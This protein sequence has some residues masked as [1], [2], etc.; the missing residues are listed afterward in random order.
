MLVTIL[1]F[2]VGLAIG[3]LVGNRNIA[4]KAEVVQKALDT[5]KPEAPKE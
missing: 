1:S 5:I 3:I 2:L 4:P